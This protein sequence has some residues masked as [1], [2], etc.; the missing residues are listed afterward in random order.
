MA[1]APN[2]ITIL[3]QMSPEFSMDNIIVASGGA[4]TI[5]RGTPTKSADAYN[6]SNT[7]A[8]VPMVDADGT[9]AQFFT[10]IATVNSTDTA[11]A[12]GV[13]TTWLPLPG[14]VYS[15]AAKDSTTFDTASEI[16]IAYQKCALFD[17]TSVTWS[18]D[19]AAS[20]DKKVNCIVIVGGDPN[21]STVYF[22]YAPK[23]TMLNYC[24]SG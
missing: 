22:Y 2:A 9:T 3:N 21:T 8:V 19:V 18:I 10:G 20:N 13:V 6:A 4:A 1:A 12:A 15:C 24:I 5:S 23:G 17:L 14:L 16:K 7:G 11:G